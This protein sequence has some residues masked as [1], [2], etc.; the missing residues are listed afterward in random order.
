M[1]QEAI[2]RVRD[3]QKRAQNYIGPNGHKPPPKVENRPNPN[4]KP[5]P[6]PQNSPNNMGNQNMQSTLGN[7]LNMGNLTGVEGILKDFNIDN[8][9][10]LI[11]ILAYLLYKNNADLK[12][13]I[14][15][16][17]LLL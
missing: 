11:G 17:Y 3:M 16:G 13:I 9:K 4:P 5:K 10:I 6:A 15:L 2:R 7:L 1:Q 8:E 14:A 12:L